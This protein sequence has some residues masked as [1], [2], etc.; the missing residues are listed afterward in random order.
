MNYIAFLVFCIG[1]VPTFVKASCEHFSDYIWNSLQKSD[2]PLTGWNKIIHDN[3]FG[4]DGE[5]VDC[6]K[7][8]FEDYYKY[9]RAYPD[10]FVVKYDKDLNRI[11]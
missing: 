1:L 5:I 6:Y 7:E 11:W 4:S 2:K 9:D 3:V 10:R 8:D